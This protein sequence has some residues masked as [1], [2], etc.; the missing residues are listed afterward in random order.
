M[1]KCVSG[2]GAEKRNHDN[3]QTNE[4]KKLKVQQEQYN[5]PVQNKFE[6]LNNGD[7]E[8]NTNMDF[9]ESNSNKQ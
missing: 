1:S 6:I 2:I 3:V 8:N 9:T 7:E 5:V 4:A